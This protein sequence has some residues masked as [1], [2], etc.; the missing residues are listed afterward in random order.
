MQISGSFRKRN[1]SGVTFPI[2]R[3]RAHGIS[4]GRPATDPNELW[5]DM[6]S[7]TI[8]TSHRYCARRARKHAHTPRSAD[9]DMMIDDLIN[10]RLGKWRVGEANTDRLF[11]IFI[12]YRRCSRRVVRRTRQ[13]ILAV[14]VVTWH[15]ECWAPWRSWGRFRAQLTRGFGDN[16]A[17]LGIIVFQNASN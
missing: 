12:M 5:Q 2:C 1:I 3:K 6:P 7:M 10:V 16:T 4:S 13:A 15:A 11:Y 8:S 17:G 9:M 14:R